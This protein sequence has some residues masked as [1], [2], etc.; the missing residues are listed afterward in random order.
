MFRHPPWTSLIDTE[1]AKA[2]ET[3][4]VDSMYLVYG[5]C[6]F[7]A[8]ILLLW[9]QEEHLTCKSSVMRHWCGYLS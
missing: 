6:S 1:V 5:T 2:L 3:E 4:V 8:L 7:G 9:R